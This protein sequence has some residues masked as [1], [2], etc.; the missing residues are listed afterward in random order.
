M[1]SD[2]SKYKDDFVKDLMHRE[3]TASMRADIMAIVTAYAN[4]ANAYPSQ[5]PYLFASLYA[6]F[7]D[8]TLE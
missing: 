7:K 5:I 3:N 2:L 8:G 4:S 1:V 6:L